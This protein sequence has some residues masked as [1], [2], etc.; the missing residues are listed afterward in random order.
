MIQ[1]NLPL[2]KSCDFLVLLKSSLLQLILQEVPILSGK[3]TINGSVSYAAQEA[4]VFSSTV[5]QNILFGLEYDKQ[6]YKEVFN[7]F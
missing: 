7:L 6:R 2:K 4:W 5:R 1:S 3:V